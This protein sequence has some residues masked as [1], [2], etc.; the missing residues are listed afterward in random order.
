MLTL[1]SFVLFKVIAISQ[2]PTQM[3]PRVG[4]SAATTGDAEED[5]RLLQE[6]LEKLKREPK[7]KFNYPQTAAQ[8]LGWDMDTEYAH[9]RPQ[10]GLNK[11][12]CAETRYANDYFTMKQ[13]SPFAAIRPND[14][15]QAKK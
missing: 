11:A 5:L 4:A 15:G 1:V 12:L 9:H 13:V 3:D 10:Y 6:K 2:K 8:E 14:A 7:K